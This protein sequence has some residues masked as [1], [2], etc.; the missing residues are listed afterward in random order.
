MSRS[1][2]RR[3]ARKERLR[4]L[5]PRD[6]AVIGI[7]LGDEKQALAVIDHDVRVLWRRTAR[8]RVHE[9]GEALDAAAAAARERGFSSVTVACEPTGPGGCRCSACARSG[10]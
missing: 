9:L 5:V 7:D 1:E 10:A 4:G 8:V 2:R 3:N 6:G